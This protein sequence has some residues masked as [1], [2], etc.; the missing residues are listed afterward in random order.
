MDQQSGSGQFLRL[1]ALGV[2]AWCLFV[3]GLYF[4]PAGTLLDRVEWRTVDWR[5]QL[6]GA[7]R[8]DTSDHKL[9]I[10]A[11]DEASIRALGRWPWRRDVFARLVETLNRA[12]AERIVF[13]VFFTEP[14]ESSGGAAADA[15]LVA[16][17]RT[18]GNVYHAG[19]ITTAGE[20]GRTEAP[21]EAA[22]SAWQR[23]TTKRAGPMAAVAQLI[24]PAGVTLPLPALA[25]AAR[26]VGVANVLDSGDGV[27]RHLVP[28]VRVGGKLVPSVALALAADRLNV[29]PAQITVTPG[30]EIN[31]GGQRH[32]PLDLHGRLLIDFLGGDHT[33]DYASV[34]DVLAASDEAN[35]ERFRQAIVLIGV[36]APGVY[37][38]RANPFATVYNG[39]EA[40][41]SAIDTI[42]S[43]RF[44][45]PVSPLATGLLLLA[46][47]PLFGVVLPRLRT[48]VM[49]P[50][51]LAIVAAYP[52]LGVSLFTRHR[53]LL[54]IVNPWLAMVGSLLI[55]VVLRLLIEERRRHQVQTI[56][57]YF[58][59]PQL[60]GRLVEEEALTTMRGERREVSVLF[61]DLRHFTATAETQAPE[62]IVTFLNRYFGLMHEI[63]WE[64]EGTLD[65]YI[66]D[67]IMV[68]YNAP[69]TQ[70]DHA[71]RA[72]MTAIDMQ[73][74]IMANQAEWE[75]LQVPEL[76]AVI[77]IATGPAVVG[78]I[79]SAVGE[80]SPRMQYTVIGQ[81]VNLASR[82]Q[83]LCKTTG[84]RIL[85]SD[86]TYRA[87]AD[88]IE[89]Q[90]LGEQPITGL[91]Q[92]VRVWQVLDYK[93]PAL[94][95]HWEPVGAPIPTPEAAQ[96]GDEPV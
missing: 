68:F 45:R 62:D 85:I 93:E 12:Q 81:T 91:H 77:G 52:W 55:I 6:R 19:F 51:A 56:L 39:V 15:R 35:R 14:D 24:E 10:V 17:T 40:E 78:Y 2:A 41:A 64:H 50:L 69:V 21:L 73:R 84:C 30:R 94:R 5:Y 20:G 86:E 61:A 67:E 27:Y 83:A 90:D 3:L 71:R 26:G 89:A 46:L 8:P 54:D 53:V 23:V 13:D 72:V 29:P 80:A 63:I 43:S 1:S 88:M 44:I 42:L 11:V 96:S 70:A 58:V 9:V 25:R 16:A 36:T 95:G 33:Y 87:V 48:A 28:I 31:L 74:R 60:V 66:G 75:Y 38:L 18:A 32:I 22:P 92:P 79:G 76:S 65:K 37:D 47:I 7:H 59:P 82:L 57:R 49:T 4:W 34:A